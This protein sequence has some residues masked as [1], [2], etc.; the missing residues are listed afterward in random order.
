[1][2]DEESQIVLWKGDD[3]NHY[4]ADH[5][6]RYCGKD[7]SHKD[8][9]LL[10]DGFVFCD[11]TCHT[12]YEQTIEVLYEPTS[13]KATQFGWTRYTKQFDVS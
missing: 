2:S 3:M 8:G 11:T 9:R 7:C 1:M 10:T 4:K 13:Q 12:L 6:C 5:N